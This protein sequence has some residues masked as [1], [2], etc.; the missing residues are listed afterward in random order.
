M[1]AALAPQSQ[2]FTAADVRRTLRRHR[3]FLLF[4]ACALGGLVA[5]EAWAVAQF[6]PRGTVG[7]Q[8]VL[9]I[10]AVLIVTLGNAIA[11]LLPAALAQPEKYPRPVGAFAAAAGQG[12]AITILT[13]LLAFGA[14]VSLAAFNLEAAYILLKDLYFYALVAVVL[15]H[16]LLYYVRH[17]HWLYAEF[18]GADSP[19]KPIAASGGIGAI[20]L[21][22][23]LTLLPLDVQAI[24]AAPPTLRGIMGLHIYGRDL[25]LLTLALGAYAWHLRWVADH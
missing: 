18:G 12:S 11:F 24:N 17:M 8:W 3:P 6:W 15:F 25:Y 2:P 22:L 10:T 14:L 16:V 9:G 4:A 23:T 5:E 19:L 1:S 13:Y 20:I 21:I 7:W